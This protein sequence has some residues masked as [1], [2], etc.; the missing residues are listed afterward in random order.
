MDRN[1]TSVDGLFK[2]ILIFHLQAAYFWHFHPVIFLTTGSF[3]RWFPCV[4]KQF[5]MLCYW[6]VLAG[7]ILPFFVRQLSNGFLP[8]NSSLVGSHCNTH[9]KYLIPYFLIA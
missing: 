8:E 2:I 5:F 9:Y 1:I 6:P 7:L 3:V 4:L